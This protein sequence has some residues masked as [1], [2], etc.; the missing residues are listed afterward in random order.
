MSLMAKEFVELVKSNFRLV[1]IADESKALELLAQFI[2]E[3]PN[4]EA[5]GAF[6]KGYIAGWN[7]AVEDVQVSVPD[8]LDSDLNERIQKE[9]NR[10]RE[11]SG[12]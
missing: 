4:S 12:I 6:Q 2:N 7:A 10:A 3:Q 8:S 1:H 9:I 11:D 5:A